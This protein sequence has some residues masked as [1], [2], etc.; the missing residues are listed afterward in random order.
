MKIGNKNRSMFV[1]N[2][3]IKN[4]NNEIFKFQ[5]D[6]IDLT[7]LGKSYVQCPVNKGFNVP[8]YLSLRIKLN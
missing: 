8:V 3:L 1:Y 5:V 4:F 6:G 7:Y 2:F